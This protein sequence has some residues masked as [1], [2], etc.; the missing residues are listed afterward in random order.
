MLR[1]I[2]TAV[3]MSILFTATVFAQETDTGM[4]TIGYAPFQLSIFSPIAFP[5]EEDNIEGFRF[6]IIYGKNKSV[7]GIDIGI[8]QHTTERS[9]GF[10]LGVFN[11][12]NTMNGLQLSMVGNETKINN[13]VQISTGFNISTESN[14]LQIAPVLNFANSINGQQITFGANFAKEI[15]G[16][17]ISFLFNKAYTV[18]GPQLAI[19]NISKKEVR[20]QIGIINIAGRVNGNQIGLF[21]FGNGRFRF[22]V[23]RPKD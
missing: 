16:P 14:G 22:L 5:I 17:Q 15:N 18:I 12:G 10:Q 3:I 19:F 6:N 2:V 7:S 21:N 9:E 20:T 13:G 1:G 11:C 23:N 8:I 4:N